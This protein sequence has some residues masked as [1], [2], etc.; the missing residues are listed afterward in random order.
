MSVS[1]LPVRRRAEEVRDLRRGRPRDRFRR[2]SACVL[3]GLAAYAWL[4]G[5]FSLAHVF[6]ARR[7]EN[8]RRFAGEV[9]PYPLQQPGGDLGAAVAWGIELLR[10]KGFEAALTT[11]ALSVVAIALAGAAAAVAAVT[12]SR[13]LASPEPYLTAARSPA[14]AR[15]IAWASAVHL[16]RGILLFLRAIPE[17][18]WAF[19]LVAMIGPT[20][21]PV[22][23]ALALH[24]LG[25]LG[26]LD[27]EVIENLETSRLA[28]L[29][30][31]GAG[32]L[33][34]AA[35]GVTPAVFGRFLLFFFYR[36]ESC[37][38]EATVLGMLGVVSLGFWIQDARAR[39][40]VDTMLL[41]IL[42]G[43]A[44]VLIGDLVSTLARRWV[45]RAS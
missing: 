28:A 32:R 9:L 11:L 36:W 26:K 42:L 22:I 8:L 34:I 18:V 14:A 44:I 4:T 33:Q 15:R 27:A 2:T 6:S 3:G 29:R 30:G 7:L 38:R 41:L 13:S 45:R 39:H 16:T 35:V 19:L 5:G 12:A 1:V 43:A 37:V 10:E 25:I 31:L 21:W 17:Y 20:A 23:L 40:Q 24:N